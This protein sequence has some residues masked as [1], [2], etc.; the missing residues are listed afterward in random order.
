MS[1]VVVDDRRCSSCV[2]LFALFDEPSPSRLQE[3]QWGLFCHSRQI[4]PV[5]LVFERT[6]HDALTLLFCYLLRDAAWYLR[7]ELEPM[8][9]GFRQRHKLATQP[10]K[11]DHQY[12]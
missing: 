11:A 10:S 7:K 5:I 12:H 6:A 1:A 9:A 4:V 2:V 8:Q 3:L